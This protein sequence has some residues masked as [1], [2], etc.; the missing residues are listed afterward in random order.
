MRHGP[1]SAIGTEAERAIKLVSR[2]A[3]F[4]GAKQVRRQQPLVQRDMRTLVHGTHGRCERLAAIL[5]L[6]EARARRLALHQRGITDRA[7]MRA[8]ATICPAQRFKVEAGGVFIVEDWIGKFR[9]A[10]TLT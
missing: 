9:H 5:A 1:S 7:A 8:D 6:V 3:L 2:H 10:Q 4:A